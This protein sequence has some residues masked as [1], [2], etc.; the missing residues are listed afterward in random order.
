MGEKK[1]LISRM[2]N[3]N[4]MES[5]IK[6]ETKTP[7]GRVITTF[8]RSKEK[9]S[10]KTPSVPVVERRTVNCDAPYPWFSPA[11]RIRHS[12]SKQVIELPS[13]PKVGAAPKLNWISILAAPVCMIFVMLI[14]AVVLGTNTMVYMLP[15]QLIGVAV[16]VINYFTQ[17][18]TH[19]SSVAEINEKYETLLTEKEKALND[20]ANKTRQILTEENPSAKTCL[21]MPSTKNHLWERTRGDNDFLTVRIGTGE[22]DVSD[23]VKGPKSEEFQESSE[24]EEK[25]RKIAD[26][27]KTIDDCPILCNLLK[28]QTTG[29]IGNRSVVLNIVRQMVLGITCLH[30]YDDVKIIMLYP[31]MESKSWDIFRFLPH[32]FDHQHQN[33]FMTCDRIEAAIILGQLKKSLT[34]R[35]AAKGSFFSSS[36]VALPHYV[37]FI[38]DPVYIQNDEI[39]ELLCSNDERLGISTVFVYKNRSQIP[40]RCKQIIEARDLDDNEQYETEDINVTNLFSSELINDD[41]MD[42]YSRELSPIRLIQSTGDKGLPNSITL[43]EA[44]GVNNPDSLHIIERW[45]NNAAY[46]SMRVPIGVCSDGSLFEFDIHEKQCGPMG[47]IAGTTRSGK[48]DLLRTWVTE[49]ALSFSPD[50]VAFVL[51]DFKGSS[52]TAPFIGMPHLAGA[53][54]NLD[55]DPDRDDFI[56]RYATSLKSEISRRQRILREAGADGNIL[57]YHQKKHEGKVSTP[58]PFLMIV[59]DEFAEI[60]SQYPEFMKLVESLYATGGSL[61][62][63]VLLAT[64]HPSSAINDKIRANTAFRWCLRVESDADSKEMLGIPDAAHLSEIPGRGFIRVDKMRINKEIQGLWCGAPYSPFQMVQGNFDPVAI[65]RRNGA[66]TIRKTDSFKRNDEESETKAIVRKL[67]DIAKEHG[68]AHVHR[69]WQS[70]L[71]RVLLL[72]SITNTFDKNSWKRDE[73]K[74]LEAVVGLADVPS[75]QRQEPLKVNFTENG[76]GIIYGAPQTGKTTFVFTLL[77][78]IAK[79]YLPSECNFFLLDYNTGSLSA[80]AEYP[81]LLETC[82]LFDEKNKLQHVLESVDTEMVQRRRIFSDHSINDYNAFLQSKLHEEIDLPFIVVVIDGYGELRR[83]YSEIIDPFIENLIRNGSHYGIYCFLTAGE[84]RD[85]YRISGS[86]KPTMRYVLQMA[87]KNEYG[88]I[89]GVRGTTPASYRGRGIC[90]WDAQVVEFQTALP[91]ERE[92]DLDRIIEILKQSG[93]KIKERVGKYTLKKHQIEIPDVIPYGSIKAEPWCPV[94]GVSLTDL[95]PVTHDFTR[96]PALLIVGDETATTTDYMRLV[97]R[98]MSEN[99]EGELFL[100]F[101]NEFYLNEIRTET[102]YLKFGDMLLDLKEELRNRLTLW[103]QDKSKSFSPI[104]IAVYNLPKFISESSS[105]IK[106]TLGAMMRIGKSASVYLIASGKMDEIAKLYDEEDETIRRYFNRGIIL[107]SSKW[108]AQPLFSQYIG[109]AN[110]DDRQLLYLSYDTE[111]GLMNKTAFKAMR[112]N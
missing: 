105:E 34:E 35:L 61:G 69:V 54:S 87:A 83:L 86:I 36:E 49:M 71:P 59:L 33:R 84:E 46:K 109:D 56:I 106:E 91:L 45:K 27:Y 26:D 1:K 101:G 77:S 68:Y 108:K 85:T 5:G 98:Q 30:N 48:T 39:S 79:T 4:P 64:Q 74:Q 21:S 50:D 89:L 97:L 95:S 16:S 37:I 6:E 25:A 22:I 67:S 9:P 18:K 63:Y 2:G 110:K 42:R 20:R 23:Y 66:L 44:H 24:L 55:V 112:S 93:K 75:L 7:K 11:A 12:I 72:N 70:N 60:K 53:I 82:T 43:L 8:G 29:I 96:L 28:N 58:L 90:R 102:D 32:V 78:Y 41:E 17:K 73:K 62:M 31:Q 57:K 19:N 47:L 15:M 14:M 10:S 99:Y 52:L 65:V 13:M 104:V 81:H 107:D 92:H 38:A 3:N 51:I 94:L 100:S 88:S 80:F 76:S 40:S 103:K 111:K